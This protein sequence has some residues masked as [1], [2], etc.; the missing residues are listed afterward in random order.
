[1]TFVTDSAFYNIR[2]ET[3]SFSRKDDLREVNQMK[4]LIRITRAVG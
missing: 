4:I 2:D 1:M 3:R